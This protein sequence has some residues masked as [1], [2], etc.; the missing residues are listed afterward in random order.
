MLYRFLLVLTAVT[1]V[2]HCG[3]P[4][5]GASQGKVHKPAIISAPQDTSGGQDAA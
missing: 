1:V 5:R 3:K 2:A 4:H